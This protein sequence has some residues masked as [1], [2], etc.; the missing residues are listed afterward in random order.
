M[1]FLVIGGNGFI[2]SHVV[3]ELLLSGHKVRVLD[4]GYEA[5]R[6]PLPNVDY[7]IGSFADKPLLIEA[8]ESIDV[9]IHLISATV[10]STSN[11]DPVFD[12]NAN[13]IATVSLLE[14]LR[15]SDVRKIIYFS[16]GGTVYGVPDV[17]PVNECARLNPICSYG[18]VKVAIENYLFMYHKLYGL[19]YVVLRASNP[20]GE[21]QGHI[22][23]QGVISTFVNAVLNDEDVTIWG[24]GEIIRDYIYVKDLAKLCVVASNSNCVGVFNAGSGVGLSLNDLVATLG[25]VSKREI[26]PKYLSSRGF[27][28]PKIVLDVK[29]A[30]TTFNWEC[31][32]NITCGLKITWNWFQSVK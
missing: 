12:V 30:K 1:K 13:L 14:L 23:V 24:D 15:E 32:T 27:D 29:R 11:R 31:N 21:R 6:N 18:I 10:P 3:D 19:E 4:R 26:N 16:S 17:T 20:Y 25:S 28:V 22:G 5:Y 7:R 9:V 2:G 8:L